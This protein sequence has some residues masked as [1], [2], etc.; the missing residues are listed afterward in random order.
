MP[1]LSALYAEASSMTLEM[2]FR[3]ILILTLIKSFNVLGSVKESS[4]RKKSNDLL[5]SQTQTWLLV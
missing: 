3:P 1:I 5:I 4:Q 2:G